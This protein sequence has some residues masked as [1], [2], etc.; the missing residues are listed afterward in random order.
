MRLGLPDSETVV[1]F[2][3]PERPHGDELTFFGV[4]IAG[5]GLEAQTSVESIGGDELGDFLRSLGGE[6]RPWDGEK[7]WQSLAREV[8]VAA[9]CDVHGHVSLAVTISPRPW[10]PSWSA[11]A[12]VE[13][14]LGELIE[15]ASDVDYWF[16]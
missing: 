5:P 10:E 3:R 16:R 6:A 15:V 2:S 7:L 4:R 11:T 9:T 14:T 8:T 12:R 13:Y 1:E